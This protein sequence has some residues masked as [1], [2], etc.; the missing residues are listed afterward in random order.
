MADINIRGV[1]PVVIE[2]PGKQLFQGLGQTLLRGFVSDMFYQARE[3]RTQNLT[4]LWQGAKMN[5]E[6]IMGLSDPK[7]VEDALNNFRVEFD[8][9]NTSEKAKETIAPFINKLEV[10]LDKMIKQDPVNRAAIIGKGHKADVADIISDKELYSDI[11]LLKES[12][13]AIQ[14]DIDNIYTEAVPSLSPKVRKASINAATS[15]LNEEIMNKKYPE[16]AKKY[17]QTS[18]VPRDDLSSEDLEQM[19]IDAAFIEGGVKEASRIIDED[20]QIMEELDP[21][22][23]IKDVKKDYLLAGVLKDMESQKN[24]LTRKRK[25][26][27]RKNEFANSVLDLG[28]RMDEAKLDPDE[29]GT[30][31]KE[32]L[33]KMAELIK[34]N[35]AYLDATDKKILENMTKERNTVVGGLTILNAIDRLQKEAIISDEARTYLDTASDFA[36]DA[37][38]NENTNSATHA[39]T[40]YKKAI[41]SERAQK[42]KIRQERKD[43]ITKI[44]GSA[45]GQIN[46]AV[47]NIAEKLDTKE[48]RA[49]NLSSEYDIG[50]AYE[51][52]NKIANIFQNFS[53]DRDA[54][55][56]A[57]KHEI[58]KELAKLV[59]SSDLDSVEKVDKP[60]V[61]DLAN[62]A[63]EGS[64]EA[65][66]QLYSMLKDLD[67][68]MDFAGWT[69]DKDTN[70]Q[71]LYKQYLSL[72][73]ILYNTDIE[74]T[75]K[76]GADYGYG[77][78]IEAGSMIGNTATGEDT[79]W[80]LD[81]K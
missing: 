4:S 7:E 59:K 14:N 49:K 18:G 11:D 57:Y 52:N 25:V 24:M 70:A 51:L 10:H 72:H 76:F 8:N 45:R 81:L 1:S 2:D 54:N 75:E 77:Q 23:Y 71:S 43:E 37:V 21:L 53:L 50:G 39:N 27:E 38:V 3:E 19:Q 33:D 35:S 56:K 67:T 58:G 69:G 78:V 47:K 36:Q 66:D 73:K 42:V 20:A 48:K 30:L 80:I 64:F 44:E 31:S 68:D 5:T 55:I 28:I 22:Q 17:L 74:L 61:N 13:E 34:N 26:A 62:A 79:S 46:T 40:Y 65:S 63:M 15:F 9:P 41:T 29:Y 12:E 32:Y 6:T 16:F 60:I